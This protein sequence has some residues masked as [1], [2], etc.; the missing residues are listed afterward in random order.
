MTFTMDADLSLSVSGGGHSGQVADGR[1]YSG[2]M[3]KKVSTKMK[4]K[5]VDGWEIGI[6]GRPHRPHT[7]PRPPHTRAALRA[8]SPAC[9]PPRPTCSITGGGSVVAYSISKPQG[10]PGGC[11][12]SAH[13]SRARAL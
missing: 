12:L 7:P 6:P 3:V 1:E 9:H 8:L 13:A 10:L 2:S 4:K 11:A 5:Q